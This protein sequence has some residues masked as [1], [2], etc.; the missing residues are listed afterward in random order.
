MIKKSYV[1]A[2]INLSKVHYLYLKFRSYIVKRG[3]IQWNG[4]PFCGK[5]SLFKRFYDIQKVSVLYSF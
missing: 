5:T 3:S 2:L 4:T 1:K